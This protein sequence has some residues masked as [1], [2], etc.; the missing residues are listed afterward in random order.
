M[1]DIDYIQKIIDNICKSQANTSI[2]TLKQE[3]I[4]LLHYVSKFSVSKSSIQM[5]Y[6][7]F[8]GSLV[9]IGSSKDQFRISH[10][11]YAMASSDELL[12]EVIGIVEEIK[13]DPS[14]IVQINDLYNKKIDVTINDIINV[15]RSLKD[16]KDYQEE[17]DKLVSNEKVPSG[18]DIL[19]L[20]IEL[21]P[22]N[23]KE[24][25]VLLYIDRPNEPS[26][27]EILSI[28]RE[29]TDNNDIIIEINRLEKRRINIIL[30]ER[31]AEPIHKLCRS[32]I[33][34]EPDQ[35][36]AIY[37]KLKGILNM[38]KKPIS[39]NI[40]LGAM[41]FSQIH[42]SGIIQQE[43]MN[44][45]ITYSLSKKDMDIIKTMHNYMRHFELESSPLYIKLTS[46][47]DGYNSYIAKLGIKCTNPKFYTNAFNAMYNM[48]INYPYMNDFDIFDTKLESERIIIQPKQPIILVDT[49]SNAYTSSN[50]PLIAIHDGKNLIYKVY[51]RTKKNPNWTLNIKPYTMRIVIRI[52]NLSNKYQILEYNSNTN[53]FIFLREDKYLPLDNIMRL[54]SEHLRINTLP[55]PISSTYTYSF[56]TNFI[57]SD[58]GNIGIDRNVLAWLITNPPPEY[59]TQMYRDS[60][61]GNIIYKGPCFDSYIFVKEDNKSDALKKHINI[62]IQ[63]GTEKMYMSISQVKTSSKLVVRKLNESNEYDYMGFKKDQNYFRIRINKCPSVHHAHICQE[64]YKHI[65]SMY[66]KYFKDVRE[67]LINEIIPPSCLADI[68]M[69]N[70]PQIMKLITVMPSI[71]EICAYHDPI[72]YSHLPEG[73]DDDLAIPIERDEISVWES[74]GYHIMKLPTIVL[75]DPAITFE[76]L[77]EIWLRA[78]R[79]GIG[80][81]LKE[82]DK[83]SKPVLGDDI[84][85]LEKA[86][87]DHGYIPIAAVNRPS[88]KQANINK[89]WTISLHKETANN[90]YSLKSERKIVLIGKRAQIGAAITAILTPLY[91]SKPNVSVQPIIERMGISTDIKYT[92]ENYITP[93][94]RLKSYEIAKYA[95]LCLQECWDQSI[96]DISTD[97]LSGRII[98]YK[99]YRALEYAYEVNIYFMVDDFVEPYMARPPHAHFYVHRRGNP[100]WPCIVFL[101]NKND[102]SKPDI[103]IT[104][105]TP[106]L[107]MQSKYD[108]LI[109]S[110]KGMSAVFILDTLMDKVN[111]NTIIS[112]SDN[113]SLT[114]EPS[115]V[116]KEYPSWGIYGQVVDR[117]GKCRA[118]IY[119]HKRNKNEFCTINMIFMAIQPNIKIFYKVIN[120][121]TRTIFDRFRGNITVIR[122]IEDNKQD[123]TLAE[124]VMYS[125]SN[126]TFESWKRY[127]KSSRILRMIAHLLYSS[128]N[129]TLDTFMNSI[130]VDENHAGYYDTDNLPNSMME[131]IS[132]MN[133]KK[134]IETD[135]W[136]FFAKYTQPT[137]TSDET[138]S[139]KMIQLD[140]KQIIVPSKKTKDALRYFMKATSKILYPLYF[141]GYVQYSWDI[142]SKD[143]E[144][145]YLNTF[146]VLNNIVLEGLPVSTNDIIISTI[147]YLI[148]RNKSKYLIQ[149]IRKIIDP[150]TGQHDLRQAKYIAKTWERE[151]VNPGYNCIYPNDLDYFAEDFLTN[152]P[153]NFKENEEQLSYTEYNDRV[154]LVIKIA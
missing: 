21:I 53:S 32:G 111:S 95:Y 99:H 135:L 17:I 75:D 73:I 151:K 92:F 46:I 137:Y 150:Q 11:A 8:Y 67:Y 30:P 44:L 100:N 79:P 28:F 146:D 87:I 113:I 148:Q 22:G 66:I 94:K 131:I 23:K 104:H 120:P 85:S 144:N 58:N 54:L 114:L 56:I 119:Q 48:D 153:Y 143:D 39:Q 1:K 7:Q 12:S 72:L 16:N 110:N 2:L 41:A 51:N 154:F 29:Y 3:Q 35:L 126:S 123:K 121:T 25:L 93:T 116:V 115:M 6:N 134:N 112:P 4:S 102:P 130:I 103:I 55:V 26:I 61:T 57:A 139:K 133:P 80:F 27:N 83:R 86:E 125:D 147:P 96:E 82:K 64:I 124:R 129:K 98:L 90:G 5:I 24:N 81:A 14:L 138:K 122:M 40:I 63:I 36:F 118:I 97:I 105:K 142:K 62:H 145:I 70:N 152:V 109:I 140:K 38:N 69:I 76:T 60:E 141:P 108:P 65:V 50:V 136:K 15:F 127:E 20:L 132:N 18:K 37:N 71:Q 34:N 89:D 68:P 45:G 74:K 13:S 19:K 9:N 91:D 77:G 33:S 106:T 59:A 101:I 49:I 149:M 47:E 43:N 84:I 78:P 107:P 117:F 52:S 31:P 88:V 42:T 10:I 128:S